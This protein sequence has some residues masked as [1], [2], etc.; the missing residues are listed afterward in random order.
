MGIEIKAHMI[1]LN[2]QPV[3]YIATPNRSSGT[4]APDV[5]V[6]H[7]TAGRLEKGNSVSWLTNKRAKA[8]AHVVVER[9]GSI[10]QL[11]PLNV[12]CWH[13]GKSS[14][15]GRPSVN[16][17]GIGIEIVNPGKLTG[18]PDA[19]R[20]RAWFDEYYSVADDALEYA[21]TPAHGS[22]W[23]MNYSGAQIETLVGLACAIIEKYPGISSPH[24]MTTHWYI[25]PGRKVD[26]NPLFPL[27]R[28]RSRS[29]G[30]ASEQSSEG[31]VC[32]RALTDV[33]LRRWPS[34]HNNVIAIV[35]KGTPCEVL[36]SGIYADGFPE[37]RWHLVET[38]LDDVLQQGWVH[39]D[40]TVEV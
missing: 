35:P 40:Y 23:W 13:A 14:F 15:D 20:A 39:S 37:A 22:G 38:T 19:K 18:N 31:G 21:S 28:I 6:F 5:L 8:S 30:R 11:A 32:V 33:N 1:H 3:P 10:V 4:M 9:D 12:R 24:K 7:D 34:N 36:R 16:N 29:F 26:T 17:F 27:D 25:S 2:G